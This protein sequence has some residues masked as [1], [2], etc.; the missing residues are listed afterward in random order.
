MREAIARLLDWFKRPRLERELLEELRFHRAQLERDALARGS[1]PEEARAAAARRLGNQLHIR[2]QSRDR[3]SWPWLD[4][5]EQDLRH[6]LR[7]LR[8]SPAFTITVVATLGLGIGANAM[9]F[10]V[11]D[12]LMFRPM[13]YLRDPGRV[14]RAYLQSTHRG[15]LYTEVGGYRYTT[16]LDIR[17]FSTRFSQLAG[18]ANITI[19]VGA[20]EASR[21]HRVAAVSGEFFEF[22]D[23]RPALGRFFGPAEDIPP[24]GSPVAVLS[25][26]Y[27]QSEFGGEDVVGRILPI[28]NIASTVIGVAPQ[29]F[30]GVPDATPPVAYIPITSYAGNMGGP[31]DRTGYF[32]NYHWGWMSFILRRRDGVSTADASADLSQAYRRSWLAA[33]ALDQEGTPVDVARPAGIAGPLRVAAGPAANLEAKT[34]RYVAGVAGIVLLIAAA[35]VANLMVARVLRRRRETAVRLALGVSRKRLLAQAFLE[36]LVLAGLGAVA[37]LALAQWGGTAFRALFVQTE[38]LGVVSDGRT[39]LVTVAVAL[40]A[41]LLSG[42]GP[43]LLAT[44]AD[45]STQLKAG[46][47]ESAMHR[48]RTR[49]G[50]LV[51]Q[52]ALSVILLVGAGLFVRSLGNV[53]RMRMGYDPGN[54]V[55]VGRNLRGM[56]LPDSERIALSHRLLEAAQGIPGVAQAAL[57][58]SIPFWSTSTRDL[59]VAG[60]DSVARLGSFTLQTGSPGYFRAMGT[61][62]VRGRLF[63]GQDRA[64]GP[65]VAV[66]SEAMGAILW[67]GRDPIGQCFRVGADTA[68]CITVIGIA[69]DAMQRSLL[70]NEQPFR[71]YLPIE[72]FEPA[73]G[74]WLVLRLQGD[75]G[76][77]LESIRKALQPVMPGQA[78]VTAVSLEQIITPH[79][80]SWT[81]GA[82]MFVAFGG[83]ALFVAAV[84]LYGVVTYNVTQRLHEI[85]VRIALGARSANIVHLVVGEGLRFAA[86]G[87][88]LGILASLLLANLVQ[89]LLYRQSARDPVTYGVVAFLL[90]AVAVVASA[91]PAWRAAKADPNTALRAE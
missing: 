68:P 35:N 57:A 15:E 52:G 21:E 8:R 11:I 28:G 85:G 18:F 1:A 12:R 44:R 50:L 89:P 19:A 58:S 6:T 43:A 27:W 64:G 86:A 75:P 20:G 80:R 33:M 59:Y 2:E 81:V 78:Y 70:G 88:T 66:V 82:T 76:Q 60:I 71:Y 3:W 83:L 51:F 46:V 17:T 41:G 39:V 91:A 16:Y 77:Q 56:V 31:A 69:E 38:P 55:V 48:S 40:V 63:T 84:G 29:G 34:L 74:N 62:I 42:L 14:H 45:L 26:A 67:P 90:V 73:R 54:I 25:W 24:L 10:G 22:F 49:S 72:Q 13:A 87:V 7:G 47:R 30:V 32:T 9:M 36:S 37:G 4:H 65:P 79:R 5:L 61:R 23:A 53:T